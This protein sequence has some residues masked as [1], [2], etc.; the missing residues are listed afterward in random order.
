M[1][2][3]RSNCPVSLALMRKYVD[4]SIGQRTPLGI[5]IVQA[6]EHRLPLW[7]RVINDVLIID[8]PELDVGPC[9]LAHGQPRAIGFETP[10]EQPC[11]L[12]LLFGNQPDGFLAEATRYSLLLDVR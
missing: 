8:W 11:W 5:H 9:R 4:S 1:I 6:V 2:K 7:R 10:L 3:V 12:A